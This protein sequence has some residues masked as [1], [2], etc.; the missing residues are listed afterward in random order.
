MR[1]GKEVAL[2]EIH[3]A[4]NGIC[5]YSRRVFPAGSQ[6]MFALRT[7]IGRLAARES[8]PAK[9]PERPRMRE[10]FAVRM[11]NSVGKQ[12]FATIGRNYI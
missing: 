8:L 5:I 11:Q 7:A 4:G 6:H 9:A 2:R 1:D 3:P 12:S 10:C